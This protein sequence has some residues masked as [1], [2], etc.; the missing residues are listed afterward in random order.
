MSLL[1]MR[2]NHNRSFCKF[3]I[4]FFTAVNLFLCVLSDAIDSPVGQLNKTGKCYQEH[5]ILG[6]KLSRI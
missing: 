4:F 3:S 5:Y 2:K 1:T 6:G